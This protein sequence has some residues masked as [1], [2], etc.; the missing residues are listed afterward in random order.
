MKITADDRERSSGIPGRLSPVKDV[1]LEI[2]RLKVGDYIINGVVTVE[3]KTALDFLVSIADG[4]LFRQLSRLKAEAVNPLVIIEGNPY[5]TD[6]AF[7]PAA[8]RGALISLQA[9]WY[10]PVIHSRSVGN[11]TDILLIIARQEAKSDDVVPLRSGYRPKKLKSKKL[12]FLQGLPGIGPRI[13]KRLL[14]DFGTLSRIM[15]ASTTD[16]CRIGGIGTEKAAKLRVFL[17]SRLD[18]PS[19]KKSALSHSGKP[20]LKHFRPFSRDLPMN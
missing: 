20:V 13:A 17:N 1:A 9:V 6:L 7:D 11:T 15:N 16:L 3:R 18:E 5:K 10:I 2:R 12:F 14:A 8:I 4:R 19:L